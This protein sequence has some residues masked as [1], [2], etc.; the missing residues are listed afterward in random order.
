MNDIENQGRGEYDELYMNENSIKT[1]KFIRPAGN[2]MLSSQN[3][4][5][6]KDPDRLEYEP[7]ITKDEK[8]A[9]IRDL[10]APEIIKIKRA[11]LRDPQSKPPVETQGEI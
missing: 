11:Q 9:N 2:V 4:H 1:L 10:D 6:L 5:F 7:Q 3:S 8:G